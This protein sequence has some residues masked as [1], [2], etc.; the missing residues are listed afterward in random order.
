MDQRPTAIGGAE[1]Q[2]HGLS[3]RLTLKIRECGVHAKCP[4]QKSLTLTWQRL[5]VSRRNG[6]ELVHCIGISDAREISFV[7]L[8]S[9]GE[10]DFHLWSQNAEVMFS[11]VLVGDVGPRRTLGM[12]APGGT[13]HRSFQNLNDTATKRVTTL[14][15]CSYLFRCCVL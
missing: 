1:E 7:F 15:G 2:G 5:K 8:S 3:I 13:A 9:V 4:P 11:L 12:V 14:K 10:A 6:I